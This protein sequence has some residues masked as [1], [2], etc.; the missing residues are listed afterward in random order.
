VNGPTTGLRY[1]IITP[2]RNEGKNIERLLA[3]VTSQTVPPSKWIIVN[4]GST[5]DTGDRVRDYLPRFPWIDLVDRPK[6]QDRNFASKVDGFNAGY[7]LAQELDFDIIGNIDADVSFDIDYFEF[8][9]KKFAEDP[10]LGVA[11]TPFVEDSGY[12]SVTDSYEGERHVAG[13]CQLFRRECFEE[14]GGYTAHRKGGIDWIAVTTAR[15]KGWETRSFRDKSFHHHRRLGTGESNVFAAPFNYGRKDYYLGNH[16]LW[17]ALRILY[18]M[19]K[20]PYALGGLALMCGY[21]WEAIRGEDRP[22]TRELMAFHRKE[23]MQKLK[24]IS[25]TIVKRK[26]TG[27]RTMDR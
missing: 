24:V 8:L 3:S 6:V 14:I 5:D 11:G 7:R 21:L 18:Q 20:R 26:R 22:I 13:G 15:M 4:D 23:E 10:A 1:V 25:R 9:L 17:E 2:A 16:P 27:I 12:S 19:A